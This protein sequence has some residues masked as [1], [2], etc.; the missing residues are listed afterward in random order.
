MS[1]SHSEHID[2]RQI[3]L[4]Y[5]Q[6]ILHFLIGP[7]ETI[8]GGSKT[9]MGLEKIKKDTNLTE[10]LPVPDAKGEISEVQV[11]EEFDPYEFLDQL[12][13]YQSQCPR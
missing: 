12:E 7:I 3:K 4:G 10:V 11:L 9:F 2:A 5:Q 13:Q 6:F 1:S 8:N